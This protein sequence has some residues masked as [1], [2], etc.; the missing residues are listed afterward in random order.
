[1]MCALQAGKR[2][3]SVALIEHSQV[4]GRKI[5]ISGGGR[6]NFTN[7][8]AAPDRY[9]SG[10]PDFCRSALS[11]FT[12]E[13]FI[14]MV[15]AHRIPF[16][17][18]KLGQ[19]FCDES[20]QRIVDMLVD[21]C[22]AAGGLF[23]LEHRVEEVEPR[24]GGFSVRTNRDEFFCRSL[25]VATGGLSVPKV[26]A[27]DL[28]YR[29]AGQFGLR[30]IDP[31]PALDG[32]LFSGEDQR[33]FE[34]LAGLSLDARVSCGGA[35]FRENLLFTHRGLSGPAALQASLYWKPGEPVEADLL[36]KLGPEEPREWLR[37]KR[38]EGT[39][40]EPKNLLA[41]LLP[42]RFSDRFCANHPDTDKPLP[43]VSDTAL[44][45]LSAELRRW[46]FVPAGAVGYQR[47]EVTRG[48]VD[49]REL[50][51]KTM[52]CRNVPG[53]YFIGEVVD[54]TGWLGGYNFQWAWASGWAAGQSV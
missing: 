21:E 12:P 17:E 53:L 49:T 30:I 24:A 1:M 4:V 29:L 19:L 11:R 2:G 28:G 7:L 44:E 37:L 13:D 46:R 36:P 3:R 15:R 22:R 39:C 42:K 5:L 50:S 33:R 38:T 54:V 35:S 18:K 41:E 16:H 47:A 52:E 8:G 51:S 26:G 9:V 34:G 45:S 25:V 31:A 23:F 20:A 6:C 14:A 40:S 48:G 43:Q 27:T 10:N 32:F